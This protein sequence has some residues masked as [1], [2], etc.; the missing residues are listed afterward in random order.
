MF[1][2]PNSILSHLSYSDHLNIYTLPF[3]FPNINIGIFSFV[4]LL[5]NLRYQFL[6]KEIITLFT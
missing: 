5:V 6:K 2:L 4:N 3:D 1:T